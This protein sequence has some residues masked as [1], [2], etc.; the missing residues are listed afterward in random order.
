MHLD[1]VHGEILR[2]AQGVAPQHVI[3]DFHMRA[4][5]YMHD[6]RQYLEHF[7]SG[8]I[9]DYLDRTDNIMRQ[10]TEEANHLLYNYNTCTCDCGNIMRIIEETSELLCTECNRVKPLT[11]VLFSKKQVFSHHSGTTNQSRSNT[12]DPSQHFIQCLRNI[13]ARDEATR[14][15]KPEVYESVKHAI[16]RDGIPHRKIDC[17]M[18]RKYLQECRYGQHRQ[19]APIILKHITGK[20]PPRLDKDEY[21]RV[22]QKFRR[23]IET[24]D[25]IK[26]RMGMKNRP[27]YYYFIYKLLDMEFRDKPHKREILNFIHMQSDSKMREHDRTFQ[28]IVENMSDSEGIEYTPTKI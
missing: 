5:Q 2:Q 28:I 20:V 8:E 14:S 12:Y 3:D 17:R 24:Y 27:F 1:E 22:L 15:V 23:I 21:E 26:H 9:S 19:Y 11:G 7:V 13:E 16:E 18:I 10:L 6:R 4:T 25:K